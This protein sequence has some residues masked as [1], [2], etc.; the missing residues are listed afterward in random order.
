[1]ADEELKFSETDA[2]GIS[3]QRVAYTKSLLEFTRGAW[4]TL[5]PSQPF[6][7]NWH[8]LELCT[9]LED[10]TAG[11]IKRAII[12]VPPGT[13]KS[14]LVSVIYPCWLWAKDPTKRI[15]TAAYSDKR[16]LDANIK[17]RNLIKSEWFQT[18][19][20]VQL[21]E[22][23]DTKGRF[24]TVQR[25]WRIA[26]SVGGEGTGLHPHLI[27]I[28]DASTATDAASPTERKTVNDWYSS[29]VSTRGVAL[30]VI[31]IV[32]GQRLHEE[33]LP[34]FLLN[35]DRAGW[36]LV[37]WPMRFEKCTCPEDLGE[38]EEIR[39]CVLH[40]AD[41]L[42]VADKRDHRTEEGELLFPQLF[43]EAKVKQ[44]E[45]DLAN[46][47]PGQ[48]QQR[49]SPEGGS[50]FKREW[51]KFVDKEQ[52]PVLKRMTS[53]YDTAG[54]EGGG[55][56]SV[57]V[58]MSEGFSKVLIAATNTT[59]ARYETISDETFYVED[60]KV[61]RL[62]PAGVDAMMLSLANT[63]GKSCPIREEREGGASGKAQIEA[64]TR[65][66]KGWDY[67][68]VALG[69]NKL[70]RAKPFRSQVEA[71][72]VYLVRGDWN[73]AYI[74]ELCGFPQGKHDDQVDASS[75]AFNSLLLEPPPKRQELT[76]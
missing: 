56:A 51:F 10:I 59:K 67:Q 20:K 57:R 52:L 5:E 47:A 8:I 33:D 14:L 3:L 54:T 41:P 16:A 68:E 24:D 61:F 34:G 53:G 18:Y 22:D 39:R 46:D 70:V 31:V 40:K 43:T 11:K 1:M 66:L 23:Q 62:G 44:L 76:W 42:W 13:M 30:D 74:T 12:N 17:A 7:E 45:L 21:V 4:P 69:A 29:T 19:F 73:E 65:L 63:D 75:C 9:L 55:D 32:I 15:L 38:K 28:D 37:R 60:V 72:H 26:T 48:L 58:R 71:G 50:L 49:P 64:R 35:K 6:V 25:G 36:E 27:I 2:L